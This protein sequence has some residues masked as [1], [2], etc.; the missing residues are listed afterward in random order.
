M[1]HMKKLLALFVFSFLFVPKAFA[2]EGIVDLTS[3]SVS[4]KGVSIFQDGNYKV[5]GRCD[6]LV[7]PYETLYNKY[8][9]WGKTT[10]RGEMVRIAEI[11]KGY[12]SGYISSAF[13][14]MYVTAE[15]DGLVRKASDKQILSGK[16]TPFSFD[17]SQ[18]TTA[19]T[20]TTT[21]ATT[22]KSTATASTTTSTAGTVVGKIVT[23]L[24]V[25]ILV[26]VGLAIGASLLFRSRGSVSA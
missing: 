22:A 20:T 23:S 5:S 2:H 8:V 19:P 17:K 18:V 26:I 12:F 3:N 16:V 21:T 4:C 7:Y 24:L 13:D 10:S 11:D 9:L 25:V 14:A 15:K 1:G 6:G